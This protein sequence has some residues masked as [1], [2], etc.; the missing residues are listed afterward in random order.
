MKIPKLPPK[1][2]NRLKG[3]QLFINVHYRTIQFV[4]IVVLAFLAMFIVFNQ[5]EK[6]AEDSR[7]R[8]R[9]L[10]QREED[11]R[12]REAEIAKL[13]EADQA[14]VRDIQSNQEKQTNLIICLLAAHSANVEITPDEE[15]IC[16]VLVFEVKEDTRQ[17]DFLDR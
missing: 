9:Q 3:W 8:Q 6:V 14:V 11:A 12:A 2:A 13:L 10:L 1:L 17:E 5:F 4:F 16:R 7:H 15:E